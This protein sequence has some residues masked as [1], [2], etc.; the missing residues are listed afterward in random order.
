MQVSRAKA[1]IMGNIRDVQCALGG[2]S[3]MVPANV[4]T[5]VVEWRAVLGVVGRDAVE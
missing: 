2:M 4:G 1:T 5:R 3:K